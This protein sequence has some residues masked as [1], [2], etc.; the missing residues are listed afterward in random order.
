MNAAT[1]TNKRRRISG[2]ETEKKQTL[3][4]LL[5]LLVQNE[6]IGGDE[7]E[8]LAL[9]SKD[10]HRAATS[11][12]IWK[13]L[14]YV[15]YPGTRDLPL[16]TILTKA[17]YRSL[18][19][20]WWKAKPFPLVPS[21][22]MPPPSCTIDD[23]VMVVHIY[24]KKQVIFATSLEGDQLDP[25][26]KFGALELNI[27]MKDPVFVREDFDL[28]RDYLLLKVHIFRSTDETMFCI[29]DRGVEI[30]FLDRPFHDCVEMRCD[31][32]FSALLPTPLTAEILSRIRGTRI[33]MEADIETDRGRG[34]SILFTGLS[35]YLSTSRGTEDDFFDEAAEFEMNGVTILHLLSQTEGM[36]CQRIP[37]PTAGKCHHG[38]AAAAITDNNNS[39]ALAPLLL[40]LAE[41]GFLDAKELGLLAVLSREVC[42]AV[43]DE[44]L[45]KILCQRNYPGTHFLPGNFVE[46][47]GYR[48][49]YRQWKDSER[50]RSS[51]STQLPP[52]PPP[53]CSLDDIVLFV[54]VKHNESVLHSLSIQ[55]EELKELVE[56]G[57]AA[58][59]FSKPVDLGL[60]IW[61]DYNDPEW[62]AGLCPYDGEQS[63]PMKSEKLHGIYVEVH[64]FRATDMTMSCVIAGGSSCEMGDEC[65]VYACPVV[66]KGERV[67]SESKIDWS[68]RIEPGYLSQREGEYVDLCLSKTALGAHILSRLGRETLQLLFVLQ[69]KAM[70]NTGHLA[71]TELALQFDP[72]WSIKGHKRNGLTLLHVLSALESYEL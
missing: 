5:H 68:K 57:P 42:G 41:N 25:F 60:A 28:Y 35:L 46:E 54:H 72:P 66:E 30:E 22:P 43:T 65:N 36:P 51:F 16:E 64:V 31:D 59:P 56:Q 6:F 55:G 33:N 53:S 1:A 10:L 23:I 2:V 17:G 13:A 15:Q 40:V 58:F 47:S 37:K 32:V 61:E 3:A 24:Y 11:E 21:G 4:S 69:V 20:R 71:I 67:T 63:F 34:R 52:L 9:V 70:E 39:L 26:V 12:E 14:C 62:Y 49:L 50:A 29:F 48:S 7:L 38:D 44:N 8:T 19:G 27:R 18:Y 45:W